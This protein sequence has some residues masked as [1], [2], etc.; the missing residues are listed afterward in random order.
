[1]AKQLAMSI[2]GVAAKIA[3]ADKYV[4]G[5]HGGDLSEAANSNRLDPQ[6]R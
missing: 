2:K 4:R 5:R 6:S 1:L 3:K